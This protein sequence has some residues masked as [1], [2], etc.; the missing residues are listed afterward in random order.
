MSAIKSALV[1]VDYQKDFVDGALGFAGAELLDEKI[2]ARIDSEP[3][4]VIFTYDTHGGDYMGTAEGK[5]LP[6]PHCLKDTPGWAF[7]GR[8]GQKKPGRAFEKPTFG[9]LELANYLRAQK[10]D[11]VELCGLVSHI[12][13]VSNAVLAKAALPQAEIVVDAR[14][15]D[16]YD[17]VLH[18][19]ALDI[20]QNLHITVTNRA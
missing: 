1:V 16:G 9:S 4:V 18:E 14:L 10:F 20:L 11:R 7:Y 12:C 6:V 8:T 2:A 3:G 17:K 5:K 13:V 19:A 15:T